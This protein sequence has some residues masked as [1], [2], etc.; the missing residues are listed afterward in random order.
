MSLIAV[1]IVF[2]AGLGPSRIQSQTVSLGGIYPDVEIED[3]D[4]P[5]GIHRFKILKNLPNVGEDMLAS[6]SA[7]ASQ[8]IE[9]FWNV[10][11][12][13]REANIRPLSTVQYEVNGVL[14][15]LRQDTSRFGRPTSVVSAGALWFNENASAF[16]QRYNYDLL[17]RYNFAR[18]LDD[19]IS[20]FLSLYA[21]LASITSD[22]Q[23]EIDALVER[24]EP[25]VS[26]SYSPKTGQPESLFTRLR[27]ELA[28][29]REGVSVF[30][31]HDEIRLHVARFEWI[32]G[33]I[34]RPRIQSA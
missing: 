29:H 5:E 19:P 23:A 14:N 28:H 31:T 26:K 7:E 17:K 1:K 13:L 25:T 34:L 16:H 20:R 3:L 24:E 2:S 30:D 27:N 4:L 18:G 32:V 9:T 15:A 8:Q 6:V 33:R 12:Y 22:R 21:M 11:A 10:L